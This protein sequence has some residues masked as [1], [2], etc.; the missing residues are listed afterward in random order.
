MDFSTKLSLPYLLPNQAQK[1]VTLNDRLRA[2]VQPS[3][4]SMT[5]TAPSIAP[6]QRDQYIPVKEI[7]GDWLNQDGTVASS[8]N[9]AWRSVLA[10]KIFA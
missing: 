7:E 4:L 2:L 6:I 8:Q 3:V 5:D 9:G 10:S 1:H